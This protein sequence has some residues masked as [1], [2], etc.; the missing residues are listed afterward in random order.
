MRSGLRSNP[1]IPDL[2]GSNDTVPNRVGPYNA[3]YLKNMRQ[4]VRRTVTCERCF[5]ATKS[6]GDLI[7]TAH[8]Y[9]YK[10]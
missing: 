5:Y 7:S 3:A 10:H 9:Y 6:G 4:T 1:G 8:K 2:F